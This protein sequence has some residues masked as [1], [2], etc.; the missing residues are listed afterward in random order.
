MKLTNVLVATA[1]VTVS[2]DPPT[3]LITARDAYADK[4]SLHKVIAVTEDLIRKKAKTVTVWDLSE[5][6]LPS[7]AI[8][9]RCLSWALRHKSGLDD[10]NTRLAVVVKSRS[11]QK[12]VSSV[13]RV[14]GPSC[15]C[16]VVDGLQDALDFV[17]NCED[18]NG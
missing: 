14:F 7:L 8:Q 15:P 2:Y 10:M 16:K 17:S 5:G 4:E 11:M 13:L 3:L 12:I 1:C 6:R 9:G 18:P